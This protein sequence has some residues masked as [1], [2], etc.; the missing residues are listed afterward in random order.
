MDSLL[1]WRIARPVEYR[2]YDPLALPRFLLANH[3]LYAFN[4][5]FH[6]ASLRST[7]LVDHF[8]SGSLILEAEGRS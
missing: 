4:L 5:I 1:C 8:T 2:T 3:S 7:S 6:R